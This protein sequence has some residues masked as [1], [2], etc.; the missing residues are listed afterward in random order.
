MLN[1]SYNKI[2]TKA[3]L[4]LKTYNCLYFILFFA[5]FSSFSPVITSAIPVI[6]SKAGFHKYKEGDFYIG[7]HPSKAKVVM[8]EYGSL[9]C[10]HCS[11]YFLKTIPEI[12]EKFLKKQNKSLSIIYRNFVGDGPSLIIEMLLRCL[13]VKDPKYHKIL[14]N[15]YQTQS[16]W[17]YSS[18]SF[19]KIKRIFVSYG[20]NSDNIDQCLLN[21]DLKNK[22]IKEQ[23]EL[24]TKGGLVATP[25]VVIN[26]KPVVDIRP[27]SV[28]SNIE[29]ALN[30]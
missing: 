20:Y 18:N 5:I 6:N 25:M 21:Q 7:V 26:G 23:E 13:N 1:Y 10:H 2:K 12:Q 16:D 3:V 30:S 19:Q 9:T 22:I 11:D 14:S 28:I 27:S 4:L 24:I 29:L 15:L 8:I 17:I